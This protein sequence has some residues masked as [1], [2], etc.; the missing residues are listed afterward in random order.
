[1]IVDRNSFQRLKEETIRMLCAI[2]D[3]YA[4]AAA[5]HPAH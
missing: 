4:T 1:M 2:M 3:I 5:R